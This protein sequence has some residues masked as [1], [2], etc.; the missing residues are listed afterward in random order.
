[1]ALLTERQKQHRATAFEVCLK[2]IRM[3]NQ[4]CD[5]YRMIAIS[6]LKQ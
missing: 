3:P 5:I 2:T 4:T 6:L 1:M